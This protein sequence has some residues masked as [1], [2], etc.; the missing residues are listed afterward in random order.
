MKEKVKGS[1]ND[2]PNTNTAKVMV[3]PETAKFCTCNFYFARV[4]A[5]VYLNNSHFCLR[6]GTKKATIHHGLSL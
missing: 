2:R 5:R 1:H 3:F 4:F 6:K